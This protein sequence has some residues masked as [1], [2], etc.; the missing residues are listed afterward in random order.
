MRSSSSTWTNLFVVLLAWPVLFF[1]CP[2]SVLHG[3]IKRTHFK[4]K[5]GDFFPMPPTCKRPLSRNKM[6]WWNRPQQAWLL[7][8]STHI[9]TGFSAFGLLFF[10]PGG[11]LDLLQTTEHFCFRVFAFAIA[12]AWMYSLPQ[13]AGF[14]TS[15]YSAQSSSSHYQRLQ[16]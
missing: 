4:S 1:P 11:L 8:T 12:S 15:F 6:P 13:I 10:N 9:F 16:L 7:D 14:L 5:S 2:P 3:M